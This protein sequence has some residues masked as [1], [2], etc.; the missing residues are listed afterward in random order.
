MPRRRSMRTPATPALGIRAEGIGI[1]HEKPSR[2]STRRTG[3]TALPLRM[4][5]AVMG[6][7][8]SG[9]TLAHLVY[10]TDVARG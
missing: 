8:G 6:L 7:L 1:R 2:G 4:K 10:V 5:N 9:E 3:T